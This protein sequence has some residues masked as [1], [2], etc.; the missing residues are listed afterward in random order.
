MAAAGPWRET[1]MGRGGPVPAGRA[2]SGSR[3]GRLPDRRGSDPKATDAEPAPR[4]GAR[5]LVGRAGRAGRSAGVHAQT[6]AERCGDWWRER[7]HR[8]PDPRGRGAHR[9]G[10]RSA[11]QDARSRAGARHAS[12]SRQRGRS[13]APWDRRGRG[14]VRRID[15]R[16]GARPRHRHI[17]DPVRDLVGQQRARQ[18][19]VEVVQAT[20]ERVRR[21]AVGILDQ[22]ETPQVGDG[23][24]PGLD[25][26]ALATKHEAPKVETPA[27]TEPAAV[28]GL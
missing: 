16:R 12:R 1:Q 3:L 17:H 11:G 23:D 26:T 2:A 25:R 10:R 4:P 13:H 20:A 18:D 21:T 24:P 6:G 22:L 9:H 5:G 28:V 7:D 14:R 19:P 27:R 8:L 15:D